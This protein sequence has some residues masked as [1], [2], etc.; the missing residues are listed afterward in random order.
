[1]PEV[2]SAKL[3]DT[4]DEE[5]YCGLPYILPVMNFLWVT[6]WMDTPA[7]K[8]PLE[9]TTTLNSKTMIDRNTVRLNFT[10]T[11]P[12]HMNLMFSP[13]TSVTLKRW[14]IDESTPLAGSKQFK[15][16]NLYFV[17][18][19][20]GQTRRPWNF[21]L[22]FEVPEGYTVADP[23]VDLSLNGQFIHGEWKMTEQLK[24]FVERLPDWTTTSGW[25]STIR[26]YVF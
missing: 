19:S 22:D 17:Y 18:Y 26:S 7:F 24:A 16:R 9:T 4:C 2:R 5:I 20:Y 3:V 12:D 11:G 13:M 25:T 23:V 14:S 6:H 21:H 8:V 1:M 15:K 10:M